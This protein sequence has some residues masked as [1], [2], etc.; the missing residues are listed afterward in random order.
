MSFSW[1]SRV[2]TA[3]EVDAGSAGP[4]ELDGEE[5]TGGRAELDPAED[6]ATAAGGGPT[7][8]TAGIGAAGR[9]SAGGEVVGGAGE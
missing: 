2:R 5:E 1:I 8:E 7:G 6:G 9:G 3:V 4:A